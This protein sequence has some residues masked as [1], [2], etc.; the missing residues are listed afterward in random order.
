MFFNVS[1]ISYEYMDFTKQPVNQK[2][3]RKIISFVERDG[4]KIIS[5]DYKE[6]YVI[7]NKDRKIRFYLY[8]FKNGEKAIIISIND[9]YVPFIDSLHLFREYPKI[10][11]DE[12][13]A[14]AILRGADL[15]AP[16]I[17]DFDKFEKDDFVVIQYKGSSLAIGI[18]LYS[19]NELD[20]MERGKIIKVIHHKGDKL[21]KIIRSVS[22]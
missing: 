22:L 19:S 13:A 7:T 20:N 18:S 10:E 14:K 21:W 11:V 8:T 15:M 16:G 12:G 9:H 2:K 5:K 17:V 4:F 6:V 3:A 1:I